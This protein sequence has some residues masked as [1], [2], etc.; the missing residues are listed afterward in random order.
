MF[1]NTHTASD[2]FKPAPIPEAQAF[3]WGDLLPPTRVALHDLLVWL[4]AACDDSTRQDRQE[5]VSTSILIHGARGTGK[6]TILLSAAQ[7]LSNPR[8]FLE[9]G[10][11][12]LE[13][14]PGERRRYDALSKLL[15]KLKN[16][17]TW[18][19][20]LDLEPL[21][22]KANLL[23]TVLVRVRAALD[24]EARK[25]TSHRRHGSFRSSS[26]LEESAE[27]TWG[28]LDRLIR[29]ATFMWEDIP[30]ATDA[31]VRAEQQIKASDIFA[32][33]QPAFIKAMDL[34]ARTLAI[35]QTSATDN[36]EGILVLPIDNVDRSIGHLSSIVKL[37]RMAT[38]RRLWFI[39]AAGHQE[40][41]L[42][43]ER[44]AQRE[45]IVSGQAGIGPKGHD[46]TL[47]IARRQ[48]ATTLRRALPPSYRIRL[49]PVVPEEAWGFQGTTDK[50][51]PLGKLLK[52][53][54]L[55]KSPARGLHLEHFSD[56]FELSERLSPSLRQ[57]GTPQLTHAARMALTLPAR[58]LRDLWHSAYREWK[59]AQTDQL[60]DDEKAERVVHIATEMLRNAIDESE[61][62]AWAS[63]Q[64]HNRML[65]KNV[66]GQ[67]VLDLTGKPVR[68]AR[69]TTLSDMME[70]S[71]SLFS[72]ENGK[73][74]SR[75]NGKALPGSAILIS[76]LHLRQIHDVIL[77][78]SALDK[79]GNHV[80]LPPNV[81]GWFMVLHDLLMLFDEPRV[82]NVEVTPY[83]I[84]P[85][86]VV[87]LHELWVKDEVL[88]PFI[89]LDFLW[90]LPT[91]DLFLDF[92]IFTHQWKAFR[93][94]TQNLFK[95]LGENRFEPSAI[96]P[97]FRFVLAAWVDN[98]CSVAGGQRGRWN[99]EQALRV[100]ENEQ[101]SFTALED[102]EQHVRASIGQLARDSQR[103]SSGYDR[104][105]MARIWL[106][107]VLLQL[108]L[109]EFSPS[110]K[111]TPL[112]GRPS[113]HRA[114]KPAWDEL[115]RYWKR[116]LPRLTRNR[117]NLVRAVALRSSTYEAF[118]Q[119][120]GV[121][122]AHVERT[123]H[124][125]LNKVAQAWFEAADEESE[126]EH[127]EEEV[128]Q[129][130]T[131]LELE[132]RLEERETSGSPH[133]HEGHEVAPS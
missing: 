17:V 107:Q 1:S 36:P 63:E 80:P 3:T 72:Q 5:H 41:Q 20:P 76:E 45:F 115:V 84:S 90:S 6:T 11:G 12:E 68:R 13:G 47:A 102:Y 133:L 95:K 18:M 126:R 62:P 89:K 37:T 129:W 56:L 123:I 50:D 75:G 103:E 112:L 66:R 96:A 60:T 118:H 35:S 55:P 53:L 52:E 24:Q 93:Q 127:R 40:F 130:M 105:L 88:E 2:P 69:R 85:E 99:M 25:S 61:L 109:P 110:H 97:R 81:A 78:L 117:Q 70:V 124:S 65:R 113:R 77:E 7:A 58:T 31:R 86:L 125:W 26:L 67:I 30:D 16:Q 44:S 54:P 27:D 132:E 71:R 21:P 108:A 73:E 23:A 74:P 131:P 79:P 111:L 120:P 94:E 116:H 98:I 64:F 119:A 29:D 49:E 14:S 92:N 22:E 43:M 46:E 114:E 8:S 39:L 106:E 10:G 87:T 48:A 59:N 101:L 9:A 82:L 51:L 4:K 42:F 91:W 38:S 32:D 57:A 104:P 15:P 128:L 28:Q 121:N 83:E 34:V 33:F 19:D 100:K 122:P